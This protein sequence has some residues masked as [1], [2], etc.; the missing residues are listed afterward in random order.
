MIDQ[1]DFS[2]PQR[3]SLIGI[4]VYLLR[5]ARIILSLGVGIIAIG[6]EN[7]V[8]FTWLIVGVAIISLLIAYISYLQYKNFTFQISNDELIIHRGVIVKDKKT[9]P[10][11]RI[12]SVHIEQNIIQQALGVVGLKIDSAGSSEKELEI[13]ALKEPIARHFRDLLKQAKINTAE[14]VEAI[15]TVEEEPE[16]VLVKLTPLDLL[17][18]GL[19]ENHVR[20]G[21]VAVLVVYGYI[22]QYLDFAEDYIYGY[23][24]EYMEDVPGQLLRAGLALILAGVV[25]FIVVSVF[26]SRGRTVLKF[27]DFRAAIQG[28]VLEIR[29]GLL[30]KNEIRIPVHK[31]QYLR[32]DSNP[33][34]RLLGFMTVKVFQV[35]PGKQQK[36]MQV[37]IP[38]C[39]PAQAKALEQLVYEEEVRESDSVIH[40]D[41]WAYTRFYSILFGIPVIAWVLVQY[42]L[43]PVLWYL[44]L[45]L[46]PVITFV[47]YQYGKSVQITFFS[48]Y[49]VI[50]KGW[51]FPSRTV[52]SYYKGQAV[53]FSNNIFLRHRHLA[54]LILHTASGS[55]RIRYI[56]E[57][58]V[59]A[60]C[61]YVVYKIETSRK[62]WM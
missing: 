44:P 2:V 3:Q 4:V 54:H 38:A 15:D 40:A 11:S 56:S 45:L 22:T 59:R 41:K 23:V 6:N 30:K 7:P 12:Q 35:E 19:T 17:K 20:N 48:E 57:T 14:P 27:F 16:Q 8:V 5:N 32:W 31:I 50:Q 37:E 25:V 62:S 51:I 49:L 53:R 9:I 1:I 46:L 42:F 24:G 18:V 55:V 52:L 33:L 26:I 29:S 21:L 34:R 47:A 60:A 43:Y 28:E 10:L 36:K 13:A 39:Y 58:N 61:D